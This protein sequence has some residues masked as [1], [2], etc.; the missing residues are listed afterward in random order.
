MADDGMDAF[1]GLEPETGDD[2]Q[3]N[4]V[5]DAFGHLEDGDD[6]EMAAGG[7]VEGG[8]VAVSTSTFSDLHLDDRV[9]Q[10]VKSK[11]WEHPSQVQAAVI[12]HIMN[13]EDV[14][15]QAK[16]G[17]GKTGMFV[18][19]ILNQ[20]VKLRD[21]EAE[22]AAD[23]AQDA[24]DDMATAD[25][26]KEEGAEEK[27]QNKDDED[28][29]EKGTQDADKEKEKAKPNAKTAVKDSVKVVV[30][31]HTHEVA[32]MIGELFV[33]FGAGLG[34]KTLV[35][36]GGQGNPSRD[37]HINL[38]TNGAVDVLVGT[39]GRLAQIAE[40]K[41]RISF[42]N[43]KFLVV[44]ECDVIF[45]A[46]EPQTTT[47][48]QDGK[49]EPKAPQ[50]Q[51]RGKSMRPAVHVTYL[52]CPRDV[53]MVCC[54]ATLPQTIRDV[55]NKYMKNPK[56]TCLDEGVKLKLDG[57]EQYFCQCNEEKDKLQELLQ[58]LDRLRF[59]QGIIFCRSRDRVEDLCARLLEAAYPS[60]KVFSRD[61][62][63]RTTIKQFL[64]GNFRLLV[65][66]AL[67]GRGFDASS[68]TLVINYD[69][70]KNPDEYMHHVGRA[71]RF[72]S[73]G[74]AI[75]FAVTEE[76]KQVLDDVKSRF[77]T[78]INEV[79]QEF[80]DEWRQAKATD[81]ADQGDEGDDAAA[82]EAAAEADDV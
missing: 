54:S 19:P 8:A 2:G 62:N 21:E 75:T 27:D 41:D 14:I 49:E 40:Q 78:T 9:V 37:K 17:T 53:Q 51:R 7:N 77:V 57:V 22:A 28:K 68:V 13:G 34:I 39:P 56:V 23:E 76:D 3:A 69:V 63:R 11:G 65:S 72:N 82:E 58:V 74:I 73:R 61:P 29:K 64:D 10:A 60:K 59:T 31:S 55:C 48:Q 50:P 26:I 81:G 4:G 20:L 25:E 80:S 1:A 15:A 66:T 36:I 5:T 67:T 12:P 24:T 6:G 35:A 45:R 70:P 47:Q 46:D 16:A 43:V 79:P 18:I 71:G 44:D 33:S 42:D 52:R 38:I 32:T 30:F